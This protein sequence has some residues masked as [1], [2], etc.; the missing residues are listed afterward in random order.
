MFPDYNFCPKTYLFPDD[1]RKFVMD[2][3]QDN[4]K[5]MYIMKPNA[6]SCGRGIK[7]IGAKQEV[8]RKAGVLLSQYVSNPHLID[9]L[10]YDLR[11]YVCVTSFDPL[12]IYLFK[13]GLARFAT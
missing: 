9:G 1:Y 6:A 7:V 12:K 2:R 8:K 4:Y 13:E 10:K 3:E 5:H 11:I